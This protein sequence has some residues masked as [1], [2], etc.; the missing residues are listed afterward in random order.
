[1]EHQPVAGFGQPLGAGAR[2]LRFLAVR[3]N[4]CFGGDRSQFQ[5]A[6]SQHGHRD[7]RP[8]DAKGDGVGSRGEVQAP[9]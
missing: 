1:M 4:M 6:K 2:P 5:A 7:R 8:F 9:R 3:L